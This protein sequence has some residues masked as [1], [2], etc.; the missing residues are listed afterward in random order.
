MSDEYDDNFDENGSFIVNLEQIIASKD[1]LAVTKMTALEIKADGY[2]TVGRYLQRLSDFDLH[3]LM[4]IC[5]NV[6]DEQNDQIGDV[7]LIAEMLAT[8][9]GLEPGTP[10]GIAQRMNAFIMLLTIESLHRKGL[11]KAHHNNMSLGEDAGNKVI[12]EKI[13]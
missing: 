5:E 2:L 3:D 7:L 12:V 11:V 4:S 13:K 10:A 1:I 6:K 8:A 9:E